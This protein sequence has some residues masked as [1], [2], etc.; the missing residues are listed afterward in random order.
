MGYFG[1]GDGWIVGLQWSLPLPLGGLVH[2]PRMVM[3]D[4]LISTRVYLVR[5]ADTMF[6][7]IVDG[8]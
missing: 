2:R 8:A 5:M 6:S 3:L 1:L 4:S 7:E